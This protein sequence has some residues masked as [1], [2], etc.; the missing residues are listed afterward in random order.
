M[1]GVNRAAPGVMD[2]PQ[3][4]VASSSVFRLPE[5]VMA[6]APRQGVTTGLGHL[7]NSL[8]AHTDAVIAIGGGGGTMCHQQ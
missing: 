1:P 8:V 5:A 7:R 6:R 2:F 4:V 3:S